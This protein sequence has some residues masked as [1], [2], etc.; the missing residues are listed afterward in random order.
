MKTLEQLAN[1]EKKLLKFFTFFCIT[2]SLL[3]FVLGIIVGLLLS[4]L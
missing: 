2:G 1:E 3:L 4:M